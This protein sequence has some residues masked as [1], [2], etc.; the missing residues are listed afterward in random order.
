MDMYQHD[1]ESAFRFVLCGSLEGAA[2]RELEYAWKTALSV[3]KGKNLIV[4]AT[5]LTGIDGEGLAV[6]V[7]MRNSGCCLLLDRLPE[8]SGA[9]G[10]LGTP[11]F[12]QCV[13]YKSE[14]R[15]MSRLR[16]WSLSLFAMLLLTVGCA[17]CF[18]YDGSGQARGGEAPPEVSL[19][20]AIVTSSRSVCLIQGS[21]VFRDKDNGEVLR[22]KGWYL[23]GD[24]TVVAHEYSGTGFLVAPRGRVLTNR[25]IAEPWWADPEAQEIISAGFR[26]ELRSLKA[27]FPGH[28]MT[29]NLR[30]LRTSEES[31]LALLQAD[32]EEGLPDPLPLLTDADATPGARILLIGY[33]GGLGPILGRGA[34]AQLANVPDSLNFSQQ[35]VTQALASRNLLEPFISFGYLS[36]V[37]EKVLTLAVQTSDGSSGSPVLDEHGKVIAIHFATLTHV[38][39]G[40]LAVPVGA[41]LELISPAPTD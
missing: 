24:D 28:K 11:S 9:A 32:Q 40:G 5:G 27:Y 16:R 20:Q 17:I 6:L 14:R 35:Q 23:G 2:A 29:H 7:L 30:T 12:H 15:K 13:D 37:N 36:N 10:L 39:G 8:V 25:H 21:Y 19:K 26:P 38:A 4:D 18:E 22:R 34:R 3:T 33:P 41:A 1:C 31:D